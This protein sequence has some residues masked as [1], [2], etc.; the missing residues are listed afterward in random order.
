MATVVK[1]E[2]LQIPK[3]RKYRVSLSKPNDQ[4]TQQLL[5]KLVSGAMWAS[6]S[7]S[8]RD[9]KALF[10]LYQLESEGLIFS[11]MESKSKTRYERRFYITDLGKKL[12]NH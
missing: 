8:G 3:D 10:K 7:L 9:D 5:K 1:F 11:K 12:A 2:N 6:E 4:L